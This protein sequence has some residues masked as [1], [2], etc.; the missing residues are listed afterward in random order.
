MVRPSA[1]GDRVPSTPVFPLGPF[2]SFPAMPRV[3]VALLFLLAA[4][5]GQISSLVPTPFPRFSD[6][7]YFGVLH[8][9]FLF[10]SHLRCRF[11]WGWLV[12][13]QTC[14]HIPLAGHR[15]LAAKLY[16]SDGAFYRVVHS[17]LTLIA[18]NISSLSTFISANI[19]LLLAFISS[20]SVF[21]LS[22][23]VCSIPINLS[24]SIL[25]PYNNRCTCKFS[26]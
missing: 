7:H 13:F 21:L 25:W 3:Q 15:L 4:H 10:V 19:V 22:I 20:L 14:L 23:M 17:S 5:R 16:F 9:D 1:G 12:L 2:L 18:A 11:N 8:W 6:R 24:M 26:L